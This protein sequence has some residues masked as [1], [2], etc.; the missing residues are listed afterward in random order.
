MSLNTSAVPCGARF[1]VAAIF[2]TNGALLASWVARIPAVQRHVEAT[3]ATLGAALLAAA[4]G[5]LIALPIS[6]GLVARFGSRQIIV[7]GAT[8][9]CLALPLLALAP[10]LLGLA[11]ALLLFGASNGMLDVAQNAQAAL[12]ES[13]YQR[14][15]MSSF[16]GLFSVGGFVGAGVGGLVA[17]QDVS[18]AM[19]LGTV[20]LIALL[21][22]I[23]AVPQLLADPVSDLPAGPAFAWPARALLGLGV[24]AFCVLL[25]EGAAADWSAIYMQKSLG[26]DPG[27]AAAG[28][29]AFSLLMAAGRFAGDWLA[30]RFAAARLIRIGGAIAALGLGTALIISQP[31]AALVGFGCVGAGISFVFPLLLSA[32]ARTAGTQPS[33]TIAAVATAGYT[34]F[35][36]GPPVIGLAAQMF[37]LPLALGFVV[38]ACSM[39]VVLGGVVQTGSERQEAQSVA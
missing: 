34:G 5:A 12:V 24:V 37:G 26:A 36:V 22:V 11:G 21:V 27:L 10:S 13:R 30:D 15:I 20:A 39:I 8:A 18:T 35:L 23:I 3:E 25:A 6:G 31:A 16:H 9:L 29:A 2:F 38:L 1:A 32:A 7:F 33:A 14:S 28:Y 4:V 17:A 19:H